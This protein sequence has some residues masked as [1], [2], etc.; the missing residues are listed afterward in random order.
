MLVSSFLRDFLSQ[1]KH[2]KVFGTLSIIIKDYFS[3]PSI[4]LLKLVIPVNNLL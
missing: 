1:L 2:R 4:K 3:N